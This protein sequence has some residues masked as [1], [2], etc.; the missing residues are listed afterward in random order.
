[1][2]KILALATAISFSLAAFTQSK[3]VQQIFDTY[4]HMDGIISVNVAKPM[5]S[6]LNKLNINTDEKTINNI[7]PMLKG[8]NSLKILIVENGILKEFAE[9][10]PVNKIPSDKL[11]ADKVKQLSDQINKAV[12]EVNYMELI[13]VNAKGRSLKFLT[14][15]SDGNSIN[16]L[17]LSITSVTEG[18][19]LLFLEGKI[20]MNDVNKFIASENE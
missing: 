2:K 19:L 1:M 15:Q 9:D 10:L 12:A 13:T 20:D 17:L 14:A 4:Q 8:I 6:L 7:K 3:S 16:N 18:N 5:F 11:T